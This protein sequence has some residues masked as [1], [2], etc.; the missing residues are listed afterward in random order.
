MCI[1][2]HMKKKWKEGKPPRDKDFFSFFF[3]SHTFVQINFYTY[4]FKM[5]FINH[6]CVAQGEFHSVSE[7]Y[8]KKKD[9]RSLSK[10]MKKKKRRKRNDLTNEKKGG[11]EWLNLLLHL[12]N[13]IYRQSARV[14]WV[15]VLSFIIIII[16]I[17]KILKDKVILKSCYFHFFFFFCS[18]NKI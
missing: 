7:T 6:I 17:V 10:R 12:N 16:C 1:F 13:F 5:T 2:F 9:W 8:T 18:S 4:N 3:C 15:K 14:A 11:N